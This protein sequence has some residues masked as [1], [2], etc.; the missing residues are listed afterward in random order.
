MRRFSSYIS[1]CNMCKL[2][3]RVWE[4]RAIS[5]RQQPRRISDVEKNFKMFDI[6]LR[7][8]AAKEY[9]TAMPDFHVHLITF[10]VSK[11][12]P[13]WLAPLAVRKGE[14]STRRFLSW[15]LAS[16]DFVH[17]IILLCQWYS[18]WFLWASMRL[19]FKGD[20][21]EKDWK[22]PSWLL[23]FNW[24]SDTQGSCTASDHTSLERNVSLFWS[25]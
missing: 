25:T 1:L 15:R 14:Y 21:V 8:V 9:D 3:R 18:R 2:F 11:G 13:A 24:V 17:I 7:Y 4:S 19:V 10:T 20:I 22:F 16:R 6:F 12:D 23:F 5:K